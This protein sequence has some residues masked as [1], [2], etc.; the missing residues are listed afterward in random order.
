LAESP[1]V[2]GWSAA[3]DSYADVVR[4]TEEGIPIALEH[5]AE[6]GVANQPFEMRTF[7]PNQRTGNK[8]MAEWG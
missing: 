1:D 2:E 7:S 8:A 4:L 6:L 3:G 5:P